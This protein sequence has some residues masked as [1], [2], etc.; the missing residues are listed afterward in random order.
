MRQVTSVLLSCH[1]NQH[2]GSAGAGTAA[3]GRELARAPMYLL[4]PLLTP[5]GRTL[6]SSWER[7]PGH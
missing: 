6:R 7:L 3:V 2:M 4:M 5:Q 1:T